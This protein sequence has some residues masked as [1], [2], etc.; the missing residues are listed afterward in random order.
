MAPD[1]QNAGAGGSPTNSYHCRHT[2]THCAEHIMVA[3]AILTLAKQKQMVQR[4]FQEE[5]CHIPIWL[6]KNWCCGGG[7][8][9]WQPSC[10]TAALEV[11]CLCSGTSTIVWCAL[12]CLPQTLAIR[13]HNVLQSSVS[14]IPIPAGCYMSIRWMDHSHKAYA[15][16][17]SVFNSRT[18][19][20]NC[21]YNL[22]LY[23]L[24]ISV[25]IKTICKCY[26]QIYE[27]SV[28]REQDT[29]VQRESL[30]PHPICT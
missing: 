21:F 9:Q 25:L 11:L 26:S 10:R 4:G 1:Y 29:R 17:C 8:S 3:A 24:M 5:G 14:N 18:I 23:H 7:E 2:I 15:H 12:E 6:L 19:P 22:V 28:G 13:F 30:I 27:Y 16:K 20:V